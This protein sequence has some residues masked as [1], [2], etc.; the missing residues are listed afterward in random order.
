[1]NDSPKT[2]VAVWLT[3]V[4]SVLKSIIDIVLN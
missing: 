1:M 4:I 3:L 2:K